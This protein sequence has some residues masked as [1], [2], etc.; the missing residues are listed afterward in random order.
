MYVL[1][2]HE[3][4]GVIAKLAE[5]VEDIKI[6]LNAHSRAFSTLTAEVRRAIELLPPLH[7]VV[8]INDQAPAVVNQAPNFGL[9]L[10]LLTD[11]AVL[12]MLLA[13]KANVPAF[14]SL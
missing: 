11:L 4:V 10:K 1:V 14:V 2:M 9:P 5:G 6:Q 7:A 8:P 13:D 12:N 3:I